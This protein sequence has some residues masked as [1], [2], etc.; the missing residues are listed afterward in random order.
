MLKL[1]IESYK[2]KSLSTDLLRIYLG[3]ALMLKGIYFIVHM[4]DIFSMVSYQ[5]PFIDFIFAHY[6]VLAHI[7]GGVCLI[8]GFFTRIGSFANLPVLAAAMIFVQQKNGVFNTGAEFELVVIVLVLLL[9]FL[10][11]GSGIL[12]ADTYV[13]RSHDYREL[14]AQRIR[15]ENIH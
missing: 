1:I 14:E 4:K 7:G 2:A 6:V 13:Q 12:S 8:L 5:F 3:I 9:Y 10:W 15:K 11:N